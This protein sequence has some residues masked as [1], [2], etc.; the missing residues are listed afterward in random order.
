MIVLRPAHVDGGDVAQGVTERAAE[1]R[2]H[3]FFKT[4]RRR[5]G[6]AGWKRQD[7]KAPR[8]ERHGNIDVLLGP[9]GAQQ[10]L[11]IGDITT[12]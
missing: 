11:R 3:E 6:K 2:D 1:E 5:G 10:T 4:Q 7:A 12:I 9:R 8:S